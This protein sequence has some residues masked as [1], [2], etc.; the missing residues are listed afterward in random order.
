MS[1]QIP[2]IEKSLDSHWYERFKSLVFEDY[3]KLSGDNLTR[4][5]QKEQFLAGKIKNPSFDYPELV[6]F[7]VA[8]RL[9]ELQILLNEIQNKETN[10]VVRELYKDKIEEALAMVRMLDA[11]KRRD[12]Q[13]FSMEAKFIYGTLNSQ[14]INY[15]L[16][17]IRQKAVSKKLKGDKIQIEAANRLLALVPVKTATEKDAVKKY[18]H[19]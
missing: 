9:K 3:E 6:M 2:L 12:D 5:F 1:M 8:K 17:V 14:D 7:D 13:A 18:Y 10:P 4:R 15:V 11:T 19:H 16:D